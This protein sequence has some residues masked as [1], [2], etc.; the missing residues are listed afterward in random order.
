VGSVEAKSLAIDNTGN[1]IGR[2]SGQLPLIIHFQNKVAQENIL[3]GDCHV[4]A[5]ALTKHCGLVRGTAIDSWGNDQVQVK[6]TTLR[7]YH[8]S[9]IDIVRPATRNYQLY[10]LL[11]DLNH[12]IRLWANDWDKEV[13]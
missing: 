6:N 5:T 7:R 11:A 1:R 8:Q 13:S 4:S 10:C 2:S 9:S 12:V 3:V